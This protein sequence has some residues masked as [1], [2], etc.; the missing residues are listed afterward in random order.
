MLKDDLWHSADILR[1]F[2]VIPENC[3]VDIFGEVYEYF[4]GYFALAEEKDGHDIGLRSVQ[5]IVNRYNG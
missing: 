3:T 5:C 2:K 1:I 4:L